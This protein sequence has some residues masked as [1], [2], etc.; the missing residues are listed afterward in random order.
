V[1]A[2]KTQGVQL[3]ISRLSRNGFS[4]LKAIRKANLKAILLKGEHEVNSPVEAYHLEG[5]EPVFIPCGWPGLK[6][7]VNHCLSD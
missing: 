1:T 3:I 5:K 2:L 6:R 7:L 4:L